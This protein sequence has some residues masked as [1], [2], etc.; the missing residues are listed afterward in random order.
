MVNL[1]VNLVGQNGAS[2]MNV[3]LISVPTFMSI[4]PQTRGDR[5]L[6]PAPMTKPISQSAVQSNPNENAMGSR[7]R[8]SRQL[9]K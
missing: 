5:D 8:G 2:L 6:D 9:E 7:K 4:A 1:G 3:H